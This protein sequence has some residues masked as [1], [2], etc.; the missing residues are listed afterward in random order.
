M[1][2]LECGTSSV[3][4]RHPLFRQFLWT[5]I[6]NCDACHRTCLSGLTSKAVAGAATA[7][8]HSEEATISQP[9]QDLGGVGGMVARHGSQPH[10]IN[11]AIMPRDGEGE[12]FGLRPVFTQGSE[13]DS[14]IV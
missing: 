10:I 9:S 2:L 4:P 3:S 11:V 1:R 8:D 13:P 7:S 14:T 6:L 12:L 5:G